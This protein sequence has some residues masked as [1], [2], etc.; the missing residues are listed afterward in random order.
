MGKKWGK[1]IVCITPDFYANFLTGLIEA[2]FSTFAWVHV[3][4][5]KGPKFRPQSTKGAG[6]N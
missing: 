6:K 4:V 5:A 2:L 3:I 1:C